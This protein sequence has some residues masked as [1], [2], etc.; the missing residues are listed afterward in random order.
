[1][2]EPMRL[3]V[4]CRDQRFMS[5]DR[6]GRLS[7]NRGGRTFMSHFPKERYGH[8]CRR[9]QAASDGFFRVDRAAP[10]V[11]T[12]FAGLSDPQGLAH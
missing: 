11:L 6:K 4:D 8:S 7:G 2:T 10:G 5:Y 12:P 1:M 9:S 3:T